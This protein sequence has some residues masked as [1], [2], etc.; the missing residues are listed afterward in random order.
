MAST[1]S[2]RRGLGARVRH[3]VDL[4]RELFA[5]HD[6]LTLA[7]AIA[8]QAFFA[9][10][11]LVLLGLGL[12]GAIGREDVWEQDIAPAISGRVLPGV[13]AGIN[14]TAER[15]FAS[16]TFGL[17][18]FALLLTLWK[19]S[20]AVRACMTALSRIYDA[21]EKRPWTLRFA[22]SL[23]LAAIVTAAIIGAVV[24]TL[25]A[26]DAGGGIW[27]FPLAI[28]RWLAAILLIGLAFGLIVR[29]APAEPRPTRWASAGAT[30]VVVGWIVASL[31]F[32]WYVGSIADFKTAI[33]S[34]TV[35]LVLTAYLYTNSVIL[36]IGMQLDE[37][38]RKNMKGKER[39]IGHHLREL[40]S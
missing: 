4:W 17:I 39:H 9:L 5:K 29:W 16:D 23:G 2:I 35:F 1:A 34:L 25:V 27:G 18:A 36:L 6:L 8:F 37:L 10:V 24:L 11:A 31:V 30:L 12:L 33:G 22:I 20:G 3:E 38:L 15:I 19:L 32:R 7:S 26:K 28:A 13:F 40:F 14:Q 21:E